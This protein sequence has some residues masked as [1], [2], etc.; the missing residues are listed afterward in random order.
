KREP[1]PA[2]A[3]KSQGGRKIGQVL[4]DLGFIDD[5]QLWEILD[6]AKNTGSQTGQVA[7]QRGLVTEEQLLQALADQFGLK[8]VN[9]SEVKP[10][11]EATTLVPETMAN[12]YKVM[13]VTF[14][15]GALTVVIG[16]PIHLPALDDLRNLLGLKEVTA[17][18]APQAAINEALPKAY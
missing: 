10:T 7:L 3:A 15:D 9:L 8:V 14:K 17:V 16:D 13:P 6:E 5:A 12:V 18:L 11:S 1:K 2:K 4:V